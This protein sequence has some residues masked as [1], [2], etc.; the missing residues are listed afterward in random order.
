MDELFLP[1]VEEPCGILGSVFHG[2]KG[3][4]KKPVSTITYRSVPRKCVFVVWCSKIGQ[5]TNWHSRKCWFSRFRR[6]VFSCQ[7]LS[8]NIFSPQG[9]FD[10]TVS[11]LDPDNVD[12]DAIYAIVLT[13]WITL[14]C[15]IVLMSAILENGAVRESHTLPSMSSRSFMIPT[16]QWLIL[17]M[18]TNVYIQLS[19]TRNFEN[20]SL[21]RPLLQHY[22]RKWPMGN[23]MVTWPMTSRDPNGQIH[24]SNTVRA[25]YLENSWRCY[26]ATIAYY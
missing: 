5:S 12:F 15:V 3:T 6:A 10:V 8:C 4:Q 24:D 2:W 16:P 11:L 26:L 18:Q 25:Q 14:L 23:Q 19:T 21:F 17:D 22:N 1:G 20:Y 9:I 7:W 13:L